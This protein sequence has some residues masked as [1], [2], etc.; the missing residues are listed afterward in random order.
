MKYLSIALAVVGISALVWSGLVLVGNRSAGSLAAADSD[1][2]S[3]S[4]RPSGGP[5][6][7]GLQLR[8]SVDN[9]AS[10]DAPHRLRLSV[11]NASESAIDLVYRHVTTRNSEAEP[12]G[13]DP[14]GVVFDRVGFSTFPEIE[15]DTWQ[16]KAGPETPDITVETH[17]LASGESLDIGW[18]CSGDRLTG[19]NGLKDLDSSVTFRTKGQ[20]FVRARLDVD[21]GEGGVVRLWSNECPYVIGRSVEPPKPHVVRVMRRTQ[22]TSTYWLGAGTQEGVEIGDVYQN[23]IGYEYL[24]EFTVTSVD[25]R[26]AIAQVSSPNARDGAAVKELPRWIREA[27]LAWPMTRATGTVQQMKEAWTARRGR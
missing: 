10:D 2:G 26:G 14:S 8:F 27:R 17:R 4:P 11:V 22:D 20:Y 24:W 3:A 23:G 19:P 9:P 21:T 7:R 5:V 16:T 18:D 15:H 25:E 12:S 6:A 13:V 1:V